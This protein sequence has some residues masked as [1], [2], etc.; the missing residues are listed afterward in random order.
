M[1]FGDIIGQKEVKARLLSMV[2]EDR[3][4]HALMLIGPPGSGKRSLALAL[5]RYLSCSDRREHDACGQCPSCIKFSKLV[6]PD[7]HFVVP[8][9]TSQGNSRPVTD[10]YLPQWR[11]AFLENPYLSENQWYEAIG[12]ENKQGRIF[13]WE[14][15]ALI[16]K[17]G[18]K[19]YESEY[20]MVFIWLPERMNVQMANK[21]LK[22]L[23]EPPEKT[24]I[25]MASESTDSIL[26]TIMSR[27]QILRVPAL[28]KDILREGLLQR[29]TTDPGLLEDAV[30]RANGNFNQ[31]LLTLEQDETEL[32]HFESFTTLMRLCYGRKII[33]IDSWV[34]AVA[35]EGRERQKQLLDYSTRLLRES[36]MLH[37][38]R[39]ELNYMS[40][41]EAD[42]A[43]KFS[44]FI[45]GQNVH[46]LVEEFMLAA[47]HIEAN[48]NP[49]IV[50]MDLAIKV[51]RLLMR[52][53]EK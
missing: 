35:G 7:L 39:S 42:F 50:L 22:T 28:E 2:R 49:K 10:D 3:L 19:P 17:L 26:P 38:Q 40:A 6:H 15:D 41:R 43:G 20:R 11:E 1:Q 32:K 46:E 4:P 47:N 27:T 23:E 16:R 18:F 8:V 21:F 29:G 25:V 52:K 44:P 53:P 34:N 9:V 12:A 51:I 45:H 37:M 48:G 30:R 24:L 31:A 13:V 14:S 5:A 36:F 33:D